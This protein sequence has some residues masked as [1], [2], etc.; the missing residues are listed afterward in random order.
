MKI[1]TSP[2]VVWIRLLLVSAMRML[3][4]HAPAYR[5]AWGYL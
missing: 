2:K 5:N 3:A 1:Q 4:C